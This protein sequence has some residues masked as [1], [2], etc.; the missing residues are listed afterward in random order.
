MILNIET[1]A[2]VGTRRTLTTELN[3][4][5]TYYILQQPRMLSIKFLAS[6]EPT[7]YNSIPL[8]FGRKTK[9]KDSNHNQNSTV[10]LKINKGKAGGKK[11]SMG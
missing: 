4:N 3:Y 11:G 5:N 2:F 7:F 10:S 6:S 1:V 9:T 8:N